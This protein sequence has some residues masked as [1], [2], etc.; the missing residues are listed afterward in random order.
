[1][2]DLHDAKSKYFAVLVIYLSIIAIFTFLYSLAFQPIF[3]AILG[4][5]IIDGISIFTAFLIFR[6]NEK[7]RDEKYSYG[8]H[9]IEVLGS[10]IL[11]VSFSI[12]AVFSVIESLLYYPAGKV[13]AL[14]FIGLFGSIPLIILSAYILRERDNSTG[15]ALYLHTIQDAF[16]V[17]VSILSLFFLY[18][19]DSRFVVLGGTLLVLL[20]IFYMNRKLFLNNIT[21]MME[22]T[23]ADAR[24]IYEKLSVIYP[25]V[26]HVH[27]WDICDHE[28]AATMHFT[29]SPSTTLDELEGIK[30]QV[31]DLLNKEDISHVTIQF[32]TTQNNKP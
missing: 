17:I 29:A 27:I 7:P 1:M 18:Y 2:F 11:I 24:S 28:K 20:I 10:L 15:S 26:H 21:I 32:E 22:G 23:T 31:T 6:T 9:R 3:L 14:Y 30:N 4:D 13:P 19:L 16:T 25:E 12:I 8:Y 5:R